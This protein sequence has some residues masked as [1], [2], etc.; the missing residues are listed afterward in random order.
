MGGG[1]DQFVKL[2]RVLSHAA[3]EILGEAADVSVGRLLRCPVPQH[4]IRVTGVALEL[5]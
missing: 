3:Y 5:E 4:G 2:G 1:S